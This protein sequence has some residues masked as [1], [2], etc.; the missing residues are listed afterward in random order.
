[1]GSVPLELLFVELVCHVW[2]LAVVTCCI[3]YGCL[4]IDT[5]L[6]VLQYY[7]CPV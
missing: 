3:R 1:V 4:Q 2:T 6:H 5:C 7:R